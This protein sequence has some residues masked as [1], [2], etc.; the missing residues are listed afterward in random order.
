MRRKA[1]NY[2]LIYEVSE[3]SLDIE[4]MDWIWD[5]LKK[6]VGKTVKITVMNKGIRKKAH[7]KKKKT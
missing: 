1:K 3:E 7:R 2:I 6:F 4:L 5:T